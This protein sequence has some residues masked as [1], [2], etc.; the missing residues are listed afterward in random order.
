MIKV[1][2]VD[3]NPFNVKVKSFDSKGRGLVTPVNIPIGYCI[4]KQPILYKVNSNLIKIDPDL[5]NNVI[6][7]VFDVKV[8][9][10]LNDT[11]YELKQNKGI[12]G[13]ITYNS[14][15]SVQML[16]DSDQDQLFL[17]DTTLLFGLYSLLNHST[18][19]NCSFYPS[20]MEYRFIDNDVSLVSNRQIEADE[21]LTVDYFTYYNELSELNSIIRNHN[22]PRLDHKIINRY[23]EFM[24]LQRS[25]TDYYIDV[26]NYHKYIIKIYNMP[27]P[28]LP[29]IVKIIYNR[30][31]STLL[32]SISKE[33]YK[34]QHSE[35]IM[36]IILLLVKLSK[37]ALYFGYNFNDNRNQMIYHIIYIWN[38]IKGKYDKTNDLKTL[39][40]SSILNEEL[41][42]LISAIRNHDKFPWEDIDVLY[43][44]KA[45]NRRRYRIKYN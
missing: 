32:F 17:Y 22:L 39:R 19:P 35:Y 5:D 11:D 21:E 3:Y 2:T 28:L 16:D 8:K 36:V 9:V 37:T 41:Y 1:D 45:G 12:F 20:I 27:E 44:H 29:R 7:K 24:K 33:E 34:Q 42:A 14:Y 15:D 13:T 4:F 30:I 40:Q 6:K 10:N 23:R 31:F 43:F 38:E 18:E 26:D 25:D